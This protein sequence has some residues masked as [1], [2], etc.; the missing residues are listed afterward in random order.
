MSDLIT[1]V[2]T[3]ASQS[4]S[5]FNFGNSTVRICQDNKGEPWF[6][7]KDVADILG[8]SD[9]N[10]MTRR[11]DPEEIGTCA[12]RSSGQLRT[13]YTI[14]ESGL[15]SAIIG[16]QKPEAKYFKKWVTSEVLPSIRKHGAYMTPDTIQQMI[17]NPDMLIGLA[18]KLKEYQTT[19]ER[20]KAQIAEQRKQLEMQ[21]PDVEYCQEVLNSS[22]LHT[23]NSIAMHIGISAAKLNQF[24]VDEDWIYKQGGIYYASSKI[25]GNG[26]AD[27]HITPY[28]SRSG[29]TM[30]REHLKWTEKGRR[31]IIDL[32]NK[33]HMVRG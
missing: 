17:S 25:R 10:A 3:G 19:T 5:M 27:Y 13:L 12:D 31:A 8:Y 30:T 24:L 6:V 21:A 33:K 4:V 28:F 18:T 14:N 11:I 9:T 1:T 26:L 32:W 20:Q 7:A 23:V 2:G 29:E 15:Y 22:N 16:S